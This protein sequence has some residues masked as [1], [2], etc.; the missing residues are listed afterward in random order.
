[1]YVLPGLYTKKASQI[2][3]LFL[4]SISLI[5]FIFGSFP[6]YEIIAFNDSGI[7]ACRKHLLILPKL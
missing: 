6:V 2:G 7:T 4:R 1:M 3:M 5:L